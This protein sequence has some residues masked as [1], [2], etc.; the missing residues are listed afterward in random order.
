MNRSGFTLIELLVVMSI[1]F[2]LAGILFPVLAQ[3]RRKARA[4]SCLANVAQL[5]IAVRMYAD[6][7]DD[8]VPPPF[9]LVRSPSGLRTVYWMG[10]LGYSPRCPARSDPAQLHYGLNGFLWC[11]GGS[12]RSPRSRLSVDKPADT[13][14]AGDGNF[15]LIPGKPLSWF[16]PAHPNDSANVVWVD[17][18]VKGV[19]NAMRTLDNT[20]FFC[21]R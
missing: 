14:L 6:D 11:G 20:R 8:G 5:G 15:V 10:V 4:V 3:A 19:P 13:V 21:G 9:Q 17:G 2:I 7:N 1:V 18:H 16:F 12:I